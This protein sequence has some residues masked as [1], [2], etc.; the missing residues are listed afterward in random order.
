[1]SQLPTFSMLI[2]G[3]LVQAAN[4][5]PVTNPATGQVFANAPD[6][7][8][9]ELD[10]AVDAAR[11][12][13]PAWRETPLARRA[14]LLAKFGQVLAA[15][16]PVLQGLLTQEQGKTLSD[17]ATEV[18][19]ASFWSQAVAAMPIPETV[20]EDNETRFSVTKHVP[21]GVV[22]AIVPWNFPLGVAIWKLAP[23]LLTGNTL[24]LKPSPYTPLA[25][26]KMGEIAR[27]VFPPG[28]LNIISGGDQLGPQMTEHPGFDKVSFTGSTAT[29]RRVM[30]SAAATLKRLTL[31]LG[32]NDAAIVR[33]DV[34]VVE[35]APK[36]FWSAF[37]NSGQICIATK[38][39]YIHNDIYD[40]LS[41]AIAEV[42][43]GVKV[44][45]GSDES[46]QLGPVQNRVQYDR[47]VDLITDCKKNGLR[48]LTGGEVDESADGNFIPISLVDN[49]PD[50]SRV[51][52]E[53]A[54]GP[55]LPLLRYTDDDEV[56]RRA[57]DTPYGLAGSV[58]S[59]DIKAAA[60][61]AERLD[62]GTVWINECQYIVPNAVFAGH[63]Q[64][65]IG[66]EHGVEGLLEFT[67]PRTIV[68]P[69]V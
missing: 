17:A 5:L 9:A 6:A 33:P 67:V 3:K 43:R 26:L 23:A 58:W 37:A 41:A 7:S 11:R 63:K 30:Q 61:L 65:G 52:A 59:R 20:N 47:V 19:I 27:D 48:F 28:V 35:V 21:L 50:D 29:G 46:V 40:E 66:V 31:E 18:G 45:D 53:E 62:T 2:D 34:D 25:T 44:G 14:E 22:A 54:F 55:L 8:P 38:R 10:L 64:S 51:V 68:R 32:G 13:F 57:N 42:A 49:P 15:N 1:M 56:V 69:A 12:A 36:L 16:I 39:L 4:T 60:E 24:V